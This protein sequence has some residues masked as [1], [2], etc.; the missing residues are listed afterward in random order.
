MSIGKH[1]FW[2][3]INDSEFGKIQIPK[4]QRDYV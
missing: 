2:E 4:I 3:L 1:T